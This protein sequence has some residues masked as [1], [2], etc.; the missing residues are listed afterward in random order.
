MEEVG[1]ACRGRGGGEV[2]GAE[3]EWRGITIVATRYGYSEQF[4]SVHGLQYSTI[5]KGKAL[6]SDS[7]DDIRLG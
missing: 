3:G 4:T 5:N 7:C 1:G 6:D 2:E